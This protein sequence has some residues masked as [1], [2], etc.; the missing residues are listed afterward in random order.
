MTKSPPNSDREFWQN[1]HQ[2]K[3]ELKAYVNKD[4]EGSNTPPTTLP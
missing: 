1:L 3:F 2:L 4:L